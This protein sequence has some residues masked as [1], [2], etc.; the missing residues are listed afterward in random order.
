M[1]EFYS[2]KLLLTACL[3]CLAAAAGCG[4]TRTTNTQRTATEQLLISD[5][6]DRAVQDI[7][8][9]PLAG[10]QVFF[11]ERHLYEVVDDSYLISSLRQ[12]LLASGCI[13]KED[14]DQADFI[15]EPRAGAVGTD[16]HDL[17]FGI[18]ETTVPQFTLLAA[19]PPAI[20]EIPIAKRRKQRGVAKIAV[21][22]YRRDSGEPAWQSG[23]AT[24]E[25][26]SNDIWLLGA[27]PF[28]RG[29][30]HE[31]TSLAG[32]KIAPDLSKDNGT[33]PRQE[34]ELTQAA[35][36][37]QTLARPSNRQATTEGE[38]LQASAEQATESQESNP[39][40]SDGAGPPVLPP[41]AP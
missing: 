31:G 14:R 29:T 30:I 28:K 2:R 39:E 16:N 19:L 23:I 8:F 10:K 3:A 1:S 18:P 21:F 34:V 15:V 5:A 32:V 26:T 12:H 38:V 27:G 17:L 36:F 6:I 9:G 35:I 7:D 33:S 20:P 11:D 25:S 13:L 22:A 40:M 4:T 24:S 37:P 41:P